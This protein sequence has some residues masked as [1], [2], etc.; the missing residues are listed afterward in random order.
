VVTHLYALGCSWTEG[1]DDEYRLG[2]WV[3]RL[4]D[5]LGC[6]YTNLGGQGDSNWLQYLNFLKQPIHKDSIAV[7]GLT[8]FSRLINSKFQ[9]ISND[10]FDSN[11][12]LKYYSDQAVQYQSM[13]MLHSWQTYCMNNNIDCLAFVSFDDLKRIDGTYNFDNSETVYSLLNKD[14]IITNTTMRSFLDGDR[15]QCGEVDESLSY[16]H[17]KYGRQTN[18]DRVNLKYFSKD[19]HPNAN[20]Y[21]LWADEL[22]RRINEN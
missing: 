20:G 2:G 19:G 10:K 18:K 22:H 11:F 7:W 6:E 17:K 15:N 8:A 1:T 5:K 9:T 4:A 13:V 21:S 12:M 16:V 14:K 3:G